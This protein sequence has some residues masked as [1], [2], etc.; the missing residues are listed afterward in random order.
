MYGKVTIHAADGEHPNKHPF[1][2]VLTYL[3]AY[4]DKPPGGAKGR[5]VYI[6]ADV[7]ETA[8]DTLVGMGVNVRSD[9]AGHDPTLKV[10]VIESASLGEPLEDG[11]IPV[12]VE[13]YLYAHDYPEIVEELVANKDDLGFSYETTNTYAIDE[14]SS[15]RVTSLVFTGAAILYKSKA[16]YSSTSFAAE[17]EDEM[18]EEQLKEM[19]AAMGFASLEDMLTWFSE[20]KKAFSVDGKYASLSVYLSAQAEAEAKVDELTKKVEALEA[21]LNEA[22]AKLTASADEKPN[23]E[24]YVKVEDYNALKASY[25]DLAQ[26][27]EALAPLAEK[28]E[29]L[30]AEAIER[31]AHAR[32]SVTPLT[33]LAKYG[34]DEVDDLQATIE[35]IGKMDLDPV[36]KLTMIFDAEAKARKQAK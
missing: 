33:L 32:K 16:A 29:K 13:G 11:R 22:S 19:M 35:K 14:G 4:S 1:N 15:L 31:E 7:G 18:N 28:V 5:K 26:K 25:D 23:L 27:V 9:L 20:F 21:S 3:N 10:G 12:L 30:S 2:G 8:L 6:P 36:E 17:S 34:M 24:G